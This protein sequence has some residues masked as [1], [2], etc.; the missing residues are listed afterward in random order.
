MK[1]KKGEKIFELIGRMNP[2]RKEIYLDEL[3]ALEEIIQIN[4]QKQRELKKRLKNISNVEYE[5]L[6]NQYKYCTKV[7]GQLKRMKIKVEQEFKRG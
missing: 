3:D 7:T 4:I 6:S 1:L 5:D 2:Q